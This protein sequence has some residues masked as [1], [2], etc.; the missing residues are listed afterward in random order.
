MD[1][2]VGA[3]RPFDVSNRSVLLIALPMTLAYLSTPILGLVDTAV[4]GQLGDAALIGGIALGG[5]LFDLV[6]T[7]CNFLRSGTTGLTAQAVGAV[8]HVEER[9][10][11]FR[12]AL[13]ALVLGLTVVLLRAPMLE[14]GLFVMG[15]SGE[16]Q[17]ATRQYFLVRA[18]SAPFALINYA[19]LGWFIGRGQAGVGLV[20]QTVL[21]G[22]NILLSLVFVLHFDWGITGVASATVLSEVTAAAI[23]LALVARAMR[24]GVLPSRQQVLDKAA[25]RRMIA[26]NRDIMIRSFTLLFAFGFFTSRSAV[27]GDTILAANAILEK[28]FLVGGYFLDG[29]ATAAEQIAGRAVGARYRPAF[30]RAVKLTLVWGFVLAGLAALFFFVAGDA[31]VALMTT[32]EEVRATAST[33]LVWAALTPLFGVVAFQMDGVFIGATWSRDMR[34]MMLLSLA[35]FLAAYWALFPPFGNHGLWL[36]LEIFLGIRGITLGYMCSRRAAETF[37]AAA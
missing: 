7:T 3:I 23:G 32:A 5:I 35:V 8:D 11:F 14:A 21:N 1:S 26:V 16:V 31:I 30:D 19:V 18:L 22:L 33:Y 29:F 37:P 2:S 10:V 6:F 17:A 9:A 15:G 27:Q 28:F 36:A 13:L 20:L 24:H 4:I 12:A 34:N 25:F